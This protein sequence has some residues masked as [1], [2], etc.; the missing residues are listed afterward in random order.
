M[1][2]LRLRDL[3]DEERTTV[4]RLA[5][6]RTA[7]ARQ[8]ERARI[9]RRASQ[10]QTVPSIAQQLQ[11]DA[12]TVRGWIHRFNAAGLN[13]LEDRSR[14]G[15]PPT[16]SP[17]QVAPVIATALTDPKA[18]D[19]PFAS[20]TLDRL[21]AHLN[22]H[23]GIAVKRSRIDAGVPAKPA[24]RGGTRSSS[25]RAYAG[26]STLD[27]AAIQGSASGSIPRWPK[28]GADR[29][30][31]HGGAGGRR[32]RLPGRDG[33]GER[34]DL[35]WPSDRRDTAPRRA[36]PAGDRLRPARQGL[37]R[38]RLLPRYRRGVHPAVP[39]AQH[40]QLGGLPGRGRDVAASRDR[41]GLCGLGHCG[42]S[43]DAGAAIGPPTCCCSCWPIRAGRWCS[44]PSTRPT[45]T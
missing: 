15:R 21:A 24:S 9:I 31:L 25:P 11:L 18:L 36:S 1:R 10:G 41:A 20:W 44:S 42:S 12:Y 23:Q 32:S 30:P 6:S 8:V 40:G 17:E 43:A 4:E 45:S 3:T 5:H 34:Q 28:K 38:R 39:G 19:L 16:Y 27:R 13:G 37:H 14:S 35:R 33:A 22:E 2:R 7:P 26:A 29:G